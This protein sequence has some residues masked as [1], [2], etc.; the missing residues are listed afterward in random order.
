MWQIEADLLF[1]DSAIAE[2]FGLDPEAVLKGLPL[3]SYVQKVH[4]EDRPVLAENIARAIRE[5]SPY[6]IDYRV[7]DEDG[8]TRLV[9]AM[10]RC[11]RTPDGV[12]AYYAGIVYPVVSL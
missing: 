5:G 3:S 11:F 8:K 7:F 12:P 10:G 6:N 2:V 4:P 9:M 1:G